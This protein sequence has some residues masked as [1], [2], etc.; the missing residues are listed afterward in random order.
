QVGTAHQRAG[1]KAAG[2]DVATVDAGARRAAALAERAIAGP[3]ALDADVLARIALALRLR[4]IARILAAAGASAVAR[5]VGAGP[6][7]VGHRGAERAGEVGRR[8]LIG[9]RHRGVRRF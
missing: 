8:A 9:R 6:A 4:A 1:T 3:E 7:I 5:A 2:R